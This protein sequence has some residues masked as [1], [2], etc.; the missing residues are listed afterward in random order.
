MNLKFKKI[1]LVWIFVA[2][3]IIAL[4]SYLYFNVA[5]LKRWFWPVLVLAINVSWAHF[6]IDFR[7]ET[8]RQKE[9]ELKFLEFIRNLVE[10]VKSGI[11]IPKGVLQVA[12]KD[13]GALTPYVKKLAYQ[14]EWGIPMH[15]ALVIFADDTAN[16]VIA[17]SISIIIE[18]DQSGGNIADILQSVSTS[19]INIKK[20]KE[21]R[22][23]SIAT[24]VIQG[25]VVFIIFIFIMLILDLVLFPKLGNLSAE[26]QGSASVLG[27][28]SSEGEQINLSKIFFSSILIQGFF[29]GL[30]IGKFS[31]GNIKNGLIHSLILMTLSALIITTAKG[32]I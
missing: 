24:Q 23:S 30:V 4:D 20:M 10:A 27:I 1:Y 28:Q 31:E 11:P 18:A 25:Y 15:N 21:E 13:Y 9:I 3:L 2:L 26:L 6:W 16:N 7:N 12:D 29:A 5:S 22:R 14:I 8:K 17:R 19:V 32:G